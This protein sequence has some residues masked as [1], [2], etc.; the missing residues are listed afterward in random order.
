ML[1]ITV[2][3]DERVKK[4]NNPGYVSDLLQAETWAHF[5]V[6]EIWKWLSFVLSSWD[7]ET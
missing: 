6:V 2:E 1:L 7:D 4:Q 3:V 5:G